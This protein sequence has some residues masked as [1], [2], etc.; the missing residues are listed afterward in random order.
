[1]LVFAGVLMGW[2]LEELSGL[3]CVW[4]G[5]VD[6]FSIGERAQGGVVADVTADMLTLT[7]VVL[8]GI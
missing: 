8:W 7:R 6:A 1:M 2:Y 4:A 5:M 3:G